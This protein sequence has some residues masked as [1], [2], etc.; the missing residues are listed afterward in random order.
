V[1]VQPVH[2]GSRLAAIVATAALVLSTVSCAVDRGPKPVQLG[3]IYP[4][5]GLQGPGGLDESRGALLA[6]ERANR[7][8]GLRGRPLKV[9]LLDVAAS[10]QAPA[11]MSKLRG[12]GIRL[13]LGTYGSTISSVAAKA[14]KK[15]GLLLWETGAVGMQPP[16]SGG[17]E[18][19]FRM[20]PQGAN[21]GRVAVAFVRD[22]LA[23]QLN[24]GRPLRYAVTYVDDEYG[25][26]VGLG[27]ID[28]ARNS[29]QELVGQFG[30]DV[31]AFDAADLVRRVAETKPDVLFVSAYLED[32]IA[33]RRAT[34]DQHVPLLA[35]IGTSSSY[36]MPEFGLRLR[37]GAV[38]LFASD[39]P[40][41]DVLRPDA[42]APEGARLLRWA[43]DRYR[44]RFRKSMSPA[45]LAG[46]ANTWA[47]VHHVLPAARTLAPSD[48]AAAAR[49]VKLARGTLAN[50]A[51]LDLAGPHDRE[52][53]E[54]RAALS[55]VWQ[56]VDPTK[57][58]Q[59]V[60]WPPAFAT[61]E[62]RNIPI[63]Q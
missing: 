50:G 39:K 14:A 19:F 63:Q 25:R 33:I 34:I 21:L 53:G 56:W 27:A 28:E 35:S 17:G 3:A 49:S 32:G 55:I 7:D 57:H 31:H 11:A 59:A 37:E 5:S 2:R 42:L 13:V 24:A 44:A 6:V 46:F 15:D 10:R 54:N 29:G 9:K 58:K 60:V 61:Q 20:A 16:D 43:R 45:A 41:G 38:G 36:C 1:Y 26:A 62:L 51:G 23:P 30:Y 12:E 22:Q 18:S 4:V 40:D 8:G 47:L 48:V 52:A